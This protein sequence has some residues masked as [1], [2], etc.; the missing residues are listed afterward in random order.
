MCSPGDRRDN[1]RLVPAGLGQ[2]ELARV[3][4]VTSGGAGLLLPSGPSGQSTQKWFIGA[5]KMVVCA[6]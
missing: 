5:E 1:D 3:N 6:R 2:E 4:V